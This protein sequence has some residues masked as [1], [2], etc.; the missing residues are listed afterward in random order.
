MD[1]LS[2]LYLVIPFNDEPAATPDSQGYSKPR[3]SKG[4]GLVLSHGALYSWKDVMATGITLKKLY[5][6]P[7]DVLVCLVRDV[8][9]DPFHLRL[10]RDLDAT[11]TVVDLMFCP[12]ANALTRPLLMLLGVD[13]H[14]LHAADFTSA[15]VR[16]RWWTFHK[17]RELFNMFDDATFGISMQKHNIYFAPADCH[18]AGIAL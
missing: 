1:P 9:G 12:W 2:H 8:D 16:R 6:T 17:W 14:A 15:H 11:W 18:V 5:R 7:L 10:I 13:I 3:L 4:G